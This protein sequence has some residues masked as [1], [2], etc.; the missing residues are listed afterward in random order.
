MLTRPN[1]FNYAKKELSQDAV[2]CWLLECCHSDDDKYRQIGIDFVRFILDNENIKEKDIELEKDSP[3]SQYKNMDVYANIRVGKTIIPVIF[4]DKTDTFLHDN[5]ESK[6]IEKIEKLKTGSLFNDNGLCWREKAQYVF[7]KTGYVFDWQREVIENL[8]KNINAEVK[9]IYIDDILNFISKH[10]DKE[11]MLADYYEYLL[12]RKAS[13]VNGIEDK[14]NRYFRKIFGENRWFQYNHQ[15]WAAKRL[16]FIEDRNEKNRIYYEVRTGTRSNNGK[17]SYVIIFH[18]YRDEKSII[19]NEKEKDK[20]RECRKK[21]FED[22][23]EFVEQII[24]EKNE[25]GIIEEK[26]AKNEM[27][28]QRNLFKVFIDETNEDTVCEFFREFVERFNVRATDT[29]KDEYVIFRD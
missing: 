29:H 21:F 5:Q 3:R 20:L 14:C 26:T 19:G 15:G 12:D 2:I 6:Y 13:L 4:E 28:N 23:R 18:Q 7:F 17:Q 1:I 22:D 25:I 27:A 16:G 9:S 11:F 8:D 10:K 24:N